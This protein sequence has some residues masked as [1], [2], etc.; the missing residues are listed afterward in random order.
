[1]RSIPPL[2]AAFVLALVAS[3]AAPA[4]AQDDDGEE[5]IGAI[6]DEWATAMAESLAR[7]WDGPTTEWPAPVPRP[8]AAGMIQSFERPVALH[9]GPR[10]RADRADRALAA[11]EEAYDYLADHRW[12]LPISDGGRGGTAGFDLYLVEGDPDA[13]RPV[14]TS[15][16]VP[17]IHDGFDAVV[18]FAWIDDEAVADSQLEGCV[19]SAFVQAAL[20]GED[21]A[22]AN[23]WRVATGDYVAYLLTGRFGC[24]DEGV[25]RQQQESWRTWIGNDETSGEGG[26]L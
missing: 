19:I 15:H 2:F 10:V 14:H 23:A 6:I 5:P 21:P 18:P 16:D 24:G 3:T 20:L 9:V 7:R 1:M 22:E 12:P 25:V 26:A 13:V 4:R 8:E 17:H 11:L